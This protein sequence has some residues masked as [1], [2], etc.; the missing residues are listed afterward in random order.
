MNII[1]NSMIIF[2]I[3]ITIT[4][5][6]TITVTIAI[7]TLLL[8]ILPSIFYEDWLMIKINE[9]IQLID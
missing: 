9:T 5:T 1:S 3:N 7:T 2:T 8:L 4:I 6:I